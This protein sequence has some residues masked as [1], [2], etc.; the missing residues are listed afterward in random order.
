MA[1][2]LYEMMY[3][4][5]FE[6]AR[7]W[8]HEVDTTGGRK[9]VIH[10]YPKKDF[11]FV[12]DLGKR[13]KVFQIQGVVKGALYLIDKKRLE[14]AM[15]SPGIGILVHP[16][17]GNISVYPLTYTVKEDITQVGVAHF[18]LNFAETER[19]ISPRVT[20]DNISLIANIYRDL[21]DKVN[22]VINLEYTVNFVRNLEASSQN[23]QRMLAVMDSL[24]KISQS[25]TEGR[26]T[27]VRR[28][29]NFSDNRHSIV[30]TASS[31]ADSTT[32]TISSFDNITND[33]I[34]R[35]D[36]NRQAYG[37]GANDDLSPLTTAEV[38]ERNKNA[39]LSNGTFNYLTLNNLYNA[40]TLLEYSDQIQLDNIQNLLESRYNDL[41]TN[42]NYSI[43]N[44]L[45]DS[46]TELRN[47]SR[48]F[49][50]NLR[51]TVAAVT[52]IKTEEIP[53]TVLTHQY[54]GN[55]DNYDEIRDINGI[56]NLA[57]VSGEVRILEQ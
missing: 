54:Y 39:R 27:Y 50:D 35:F 28:S 21:Y 3:P 31:I 46:I 15:N 10:E 26:N 11:R 13:L 20:G 17:Y 37:L 47:Q 36:I 24:A 34:A 6:G 7:F 38:T 48:R 57:V 1:S 44:D 40:S 43:S 42:A 16:F 41:V 12:E 29:R 8:C 52:T 19:N 23:V 49:F 55:T 2:F 45:L 32:E 51:L 33:Q 53:L 18:T 22:E 14:D 25:F 56:T 9:T 30:R 4:A 5:S